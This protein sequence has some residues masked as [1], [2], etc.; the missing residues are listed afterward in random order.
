MVKQSTVTKWTLLLRLRVV[1]Y[2]PFKII[3]KKRSHGHWLILR[4]GSLYMRAP[5][6]HGGM[7]QDHS[8]SLTPHKVGLWVIVF[9]RKIPPPPC[10]W[11]P[12]IVE[13][14]VHIATARTLNTF[15]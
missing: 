7:I 13:R 10:L 2:E 12:Y 5:T 11:G 1:R 4:I 14:V 15:C 9:K 6:Q 8:C 3:K